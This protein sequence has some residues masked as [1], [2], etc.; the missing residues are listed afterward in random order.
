M[1]EFQTFQANRD[2]SSVDMDTAGLLYGMT[3]LCRTV[4]SVTASLSRVVYMSPYWTR[5]RSVMMVT[6]ARIS[7]SALTSAPSFGLRRTV[8][9][10]GW[11]PATLSVD[12]STKRIGSV[13]VMTVVTWSLTV[14]S[15]S[16]EAVS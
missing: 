9:D 6:T 16:P 3:S 1:G 5:Y 13:A 12:I 7:P 8:F 14:S 10:R 11:S 4:F 15:S 2:I